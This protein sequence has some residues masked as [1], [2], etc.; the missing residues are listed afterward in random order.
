MKLS[1]DLKKAL[2]ICGALLMI[3]SVASFNT[4]AFA[5]SHHIRRNRIARKGHIN[6]NRRNKRTRYLAMF[7]R[8]EHDMKLA[9][10]R[11]EEE[12]S[13]QYT[14]FGLIMPAY[15]HPKMLLYSK[16][17]DKGIMAMN[18]KLA[19]QS[20]EYMGKGGYR[21]AKSFARAWLKLPKSEVAGFKDGMKY[22][23]IAD[24]D[25]LNIKSKNVKN[26]NYAK[27]YVLNSV[28]EDMFYHPTKSNKASFKDLVDAYHTYTHNDG[29][30]TFNKITTKHN[31]YVYNHAVKAIRYQHT[32]AL[33]YNQT[34]N[35]FAKIK[36]QYHLSSNKFNG[37]YDII[38][39]NDGMTNDEP[40]ADED[41]SSKADGYWGEN[42]I[43]K[44]PYHHV[45]VRNNS[46]SPEP[47]GI[48]T[49]NHNTPSIKK[50]SKD[51]SNYALSF[52]H[53]NHKQVAKN[54]NANY[55]VQAQNPNYIKYLRSHNI[56]DTNNKYS[57]IYHVQ[58]NRQPSSRVTYHTPDMWIGENNE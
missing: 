58:R 35:Y 20:H 11:V 24:A 34:Q 53:K 49:A 57:I 25:D 39:Q 32:N 33:D 3:S 38:T 45:V 43:K 19:H 37:V 8:G 21:A 44:A 47:L 40:I 36:K 54:F 42:L 16:N 10:E 18:K 12:S 48:I 14:D 27:G 28:L 15:S 1:R 7:A 17:Y 51:F 4:S 55:Q 23:V 26:P 13:L 22:N 46:Y 29:E 41:D 6:K 31:T 56:D 5:S 30:A 2:T 50:T 9:S 52:F